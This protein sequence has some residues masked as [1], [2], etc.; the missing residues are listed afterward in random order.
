LRT[1]KTLDMPTHQL[2]PDQLQPESPASSPASQARS[3]SHPCTPPCTPLCRASRAPGTRCQPHSS[4]S[5]PSSSHVCCSW[6]SKKNVG[7][8]ASPQS[9]GF[10]SKPRLH[11][12]APAS[13]HPRTSTRPGAGTTLGRTPLETAAIPRPRTALVRTVL[14]CQPAGGPSPMSSPLIFSLVLVFIFSFP[15]PPDLRWPLIR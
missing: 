8:S 9:P 7:S 1:V 15:A 14:P 11:L 2:Q 6:R 10:T 12:K 4:S 3:P 5:H 13:P